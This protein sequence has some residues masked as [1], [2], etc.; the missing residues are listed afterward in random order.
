MVYQQNYHILFWGTYVSC[1]MPP[2]AAAG[3]AI[4]HPST[5]HLQS[6]IRKS[7]TTNATVEIQSLLA[8]T[9]TLTVVERWTWSCRVF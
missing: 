4:S 7:D 9:S 6:G 8:M 3:Q 5:L 2:W 1:K